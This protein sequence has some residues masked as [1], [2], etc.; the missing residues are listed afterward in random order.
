M[1]QSFFSQQLAMY[2][3]YHRD[4]RNR[5][6]HFIGIPA[7]VFSLLVVLGLWRFG[8]AGYDASAAWGVAILAVAGWIALDATMGRVLVL[9]LESHELVE[10]DRENDAI[11]FAVG[12]F[13]AEG[14]REIAIL[15]TGGRVT[16]W[17]P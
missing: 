4:P 17:Q 14:N 3:S 10:A 13:D 11:D 15:G 16:L 7:I 9:S 8:F 5:A 12:D 6:T 2:S 1:S